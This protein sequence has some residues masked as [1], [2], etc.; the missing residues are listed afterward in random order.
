[1]SFPL[2]RL[3]RL[4]GAAL[5]SFAVLTA[6]APTAAQQDQDVTALLESS[7]AAMLELDS[8]HFVVSTP[9]GKTILA[10]NVYL[11]S[12]EGD[13]VRPMSFQAS[14]EVS[15]AF[16]T[17]QLKAV[18]IDEKIWVSNPLDGGGFMQLNGGGDDDSLP[19]LPF[20]NPDGM[21]Q[22][23]IS[24]IQ[25][26]EITGTEEIDGVEVMV[27]TGLLDPLEVLSLGGILPFDELEGDLEPL[28]V[29]LWIDAANRVVR[30]EFSGGL[31]PSEIGAGRI[32]RRID[33]SQFD[34]P[35]VIEPPAA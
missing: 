9:V 10:D 14:A 7:A 33:L 16:L 29:T 8:F 25:D 34:E 31:L 5:T 28:A 6:I 4:I 15:L 12:V 18:G 1:M 24:Q 19:P 20:L 27:V 23:A 35:V 22:S 2:R 26:A 21:I 13:V 32:V 17:L 11:D 30:A 3:S